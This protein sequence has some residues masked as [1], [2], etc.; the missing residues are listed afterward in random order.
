M[1]G[2]QRQGGPRLK[3]QIGLATAA[4]V[5]VG[6]VVG[7]GIFLTPAG[8]TKAVG[9]PFYLLV[10]WLLAGAMALCGAL[11]FGELASL[12]PEAG[13]GYVY[14]RDAYGPPLAFLYGWMGLLVLDPGLTAA[15][16]VGAVSYLGYALTL[17]PLLV[18]ALALALI[19]LLAAVNVRGV[20]LG[21]WLVSWLTATKLVLLLFIA[22]WGFGLRL[23]D[24]GRFTPFVAQR[25]GSAP[26]FVAL[27]GALVSA[28]FSFGGWWDLSKLGGEV[29][30][31]ARTLP[32]AY[33]F[34]L[35][36]VVA[37]YIL[38][39]AAFVYLVPAERVTSGEAFA[40]QAGEALFGR[41]GALVFT[42]VVVV[43]VVGSLASFTMSAPRV[44]FAM[45]RDRLFFKEAARLHPRYR[46]PARAVL[47]Q[48]ALASLLVLLG[49]FNDIIAY[50]FFAVVLFIALAV[51]ALFVLRLE[52]RSA[53]FRTPFYPATPIVYLVLTALL[54]F[55]LAS[56]KPKQA[57]AGVAV[58]ALGLPF[59]YL[60]FR[61]G[62]GGAQERN[63][64]DDLD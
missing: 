60:V 4:A 44:Y 13:G 59:Y 56:D 27:A 25:A 15:L 21:G 46:T 58:V 1:S 64:E 29:R 16:A 32:R 31:P 18:K 10:V 22:L 3:R 6:E 54:L 9:S 53:G 19:V 48:A 33:T 23:G 28:F 36:A 40:A 49:N 5:V 34:G 38:T 11:C 30:D 61:R 37:V 20:R 62:V 55:L 39:S 35:L 45:A 43:A 57:F 8:M 24:W 42:L 7:V 63:H 47:I 14:L 52:G 51:A 50:F 17:S 2:E 26:L 12:R 41:A